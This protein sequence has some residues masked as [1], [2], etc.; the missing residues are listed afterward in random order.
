MDSISRLFDRF[1]IPSSRS[2]VRNAAL[3][4]LAG[5]LAA[6]VAARGD[7]IT[8]GCLED[9]AG[10]SLTCTANDV[11]IARA[12]AIEVSDPCDEPGDFATFVLGADLLSGAKERFDVATYIP[13]DG[14]D[15]RTGQCQINVFDAPPLD[16][17]EDDPNDTCG[18]ISQGVLKTVELGEFTVECRDENG[19]GFLDLDSCLSWDNNENTTCAGAEDA[20][21]GAPSKCRC[22]PLQIIEVPVPNLCEGVDCNDGNACTQ[23]TCDPDTGE[24]VNDPVPF[25]GNPCDDGLTCTSGGG[26]P[27]DPDECRSGTCTGDP[28]NCDDGNFCTAD[29][30]TEPGGCVNDPGPQEGASCQDGLSC[31]S[32]TTVPGDPDECRS[33]TCTGDPVNCD[34]GNFC[35]A[36]GCSE[37]G[38][39]VFDPVPQNGAP[40]ED[41][42][43][44]TSATSTPQTPDECRG[45]SCQ[46]DP[47]DCSAE[48]DQ[49]NDGV[50]NPGTGACEKDPVEDGTEC[51]DG[52]VCT[53][54]D[55]TP[56]T[57]DECRSGECAGDPV[58]CSA[59]DDPCN[60]GVCDPVTGACEKDPVED[61]TECEDG[62]AC[63]SA[64]TT[65]QTPDQCLG[66]VCTGEPVDCDDEDGCT[67]DSCDPG[68]GACLHET[69][70]VDPQFAVVDAR[71]Y[72]VSLELL[73]SEG[74]APQP[75]SDEGSPQE[76]GEV[77]ADPVLHV[78]LLNVEESETVSSP[79]S[80]ATSAEARASD[81]FVL[82][83]GSGSWTVTAT[84]V[85]TTSSSQASAE[86]ATSSGEC[87]IVDAKVAG[88]NLGT[89][90][91][92]VSIDVFVPGL[93][94]EVTVRLCERIATGAA[95]GEP[96]PGTEGATSSSLVVNGIHVVAKPGALE[97]VTGEPVIDLVVSHAESAAAFGVLCEPQ[98]QVSG[99]AFVVGAKLD[100][101]VLD[102]D[103]TQGHYKVGRV[104]LPSTG[105][106]E[107]ST[108]AHV[109]PI[110][111]GTSLVV[112]SNAAFSHAEGTVGEGSASHAQVE[113][114]DALDAG[115]GPNLT[116]DL[117]R[118]ECTAGADGSV[119][120]RT[121]LTSLSIG[122]TDIPAEICTGSDDPT[123]CEPE[124]NTVL[125]PEGLPVRVV[126]NEQ[127][128]TS[129][130][131]KSEITVNAIHVYALGGDLPLGADVIVS[132]AHCDA[133]VTDPGAAE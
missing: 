131:E 63:T 68:D 22:E 45:G 95:A 106:L 42:N 72:G 79:D 86:G 64:D 1:I 11:R 124:P 30:C 14:L 73:G 5:A 23:D 110:G 132:S 85:R 65:P 118:A 123:L 15:A 94:T 46:G 60:D 87:E 7:A 21:A 122:G 113:D 25:E 53:S 96:Q 61:G 3:A 9:V 129:T 50:C 76:A 83:Q 12:F 57:P 116:A 8:D 66:G 81:V 70:P 99:E 19:D 112:E 103:R 108:L 77:P 109:G 49:C 105:G 111:D 127:F 27:G 89:V 34:D 56:Q 130:P 71:A 120:A 55:T 92:P 47:V 107:D 4:L 75:D 16:D 101:D 31:T 40:C 29:G 51:E 35:T 84:A 104:R 88:M 38:G 115:D 117:V 128:D 133:S 90:T 97:P 119:T 39:C 41:G 32:A 59:A 44:C 52:D 80:A 33:G 114:L 62:E 10:R 69:I 125:L 100:E 24:C 43:V 18:D 121:L 126:L 36:D 13:T 102:P 58:D 28:V 20:V 6:P 91:E 17:L 37:P 74:V 67:D 48:D 26:I 93:G 2:L 54:A 98:P 78:D 82:D